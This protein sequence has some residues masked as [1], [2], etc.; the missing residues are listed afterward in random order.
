MPYRRL[1]SL[2]YIRNTDGAHSVNSIAE[3]YRSPLGIS[4]VN[5]RKTHH[6]EQEAT[7]KASTTASAK[8][9]TSASV[10]A[11]EI[12]PTSNCDGER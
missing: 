2:T 9:P 5:L 7:Y 4:T 3:K 10:C 8:L 12:K 6:L 1:E 11:A